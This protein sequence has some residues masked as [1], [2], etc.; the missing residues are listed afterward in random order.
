MFIDLGNGE[1]GIYG[2][3][4]LP[5]YYKILDNSQE[6]VIKKLIEI[7]KKEMSE[8]VREVP[9]ER[10]INKT[11][12][13]TKNYDFFVEEIP[14]SIGIWHGIKTNNFL[15][16]S[17]IHQEVSAL[18][19]Y[20]ENEYTKCVQ[21]VDN[22]PNVN[23]VITE[24]WIQFYKNSDSKVLHNHERYFPPAYKNMW[25]GA[26]Y[27]NDGNPDSDKKYSG[28]FSFKVRGKNYYIRPKNGLMIMWHSDLLHEV[29]EFYG[30]EERIVL[31]WNIANKI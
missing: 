20:I 11:P 21:K 17:A 25:S 16:L 15:S 5:I 12:F 26:F 14:A 4:P 9:D 18:K 30:Q 7:A 19:K 28:L 27:L 22:T 31:N 1:H 8:S 2:F 6:Y 29:H 24:N 13:Q 10:H 23:P 3:A